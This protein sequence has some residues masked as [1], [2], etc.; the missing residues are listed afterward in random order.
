MLLPYNFKTVKGVKTMCDKKYGECFICGENLTM[1]HYTTKHPR[2][3]SALD[4]EYQKHRSYE[5]KMEK[6]IIELKSENKRLRDALEKVSKHKTGC[7]TC[8]A[9]ASVAL[10]PEVKS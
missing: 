7:S 5:V 2:D 9:I 3:V 1:S 8:S 6:E 4:A 10:T